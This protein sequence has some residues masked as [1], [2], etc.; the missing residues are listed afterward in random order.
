MAECIAAAGA[1]PAW[2]SRWAAPA[3]MAAGLFSMCLASLRASRAS[4]SPCGCALLHRLDVHVWPGTAFTCAQILDTPCDEDAALCSP[5]SSHL[6]T[7]GSGAEPRGPLLEALLSKNLSH[8][9]IVQTF[10]YAVHVPE[11]S[12][13]V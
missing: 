7:P 6:S 8:P 9:C 3:W 4:S 5:T 11:A 2:L 13:E 10:E 12:M 1:L